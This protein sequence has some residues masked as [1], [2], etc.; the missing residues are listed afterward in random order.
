ME[1]AVTLAQQLFLTTPPNAQLPPVNLQQALIIQ[2]ARAEVFESTNVQLL[3]RHLPFLV[4]LEVAKG[5]SE[6]LRGQSSTLLQSLAMAPSFKAAV[7]RHLD[8]L[9]GVFLSSEWSRPLLDPSIEAGMV[10]TLKLIMSDGRQ[11]KS[12][13]IRTVRVADRS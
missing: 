1:A 11:S 7:F 8:L 9:K 2:T 5:V 4:V 12:S 6:R 13:I 3:I 10:D